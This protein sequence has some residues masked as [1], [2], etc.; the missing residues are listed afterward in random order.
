M[1]SLL[2]QLLRAARAHTREALDQAIIAFHL[3][4]VCVD[5]QELPY[6][7]AFEIPASFQHCKRAITSVLAIA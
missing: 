7:F 3:L 2:K 1:T 6:I 4:W 5:A